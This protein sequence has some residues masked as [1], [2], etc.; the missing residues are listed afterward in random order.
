MGIWGHAHI[1]AS[2]NAQDA[3]AELHAALQMELRAEMAAGRADMAARDSGL[4]PGSTERITGPAGTTARALN[5]RCG[6]KSKVNRGRRVS[7]DSS[8]PNASQKSR[9]P[10]ASTP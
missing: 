2:R 6:S 5:S 10:S 8:S 3:A 4:G 1:V 9:S 7:S